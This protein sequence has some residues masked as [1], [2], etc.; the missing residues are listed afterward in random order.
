MSVF[1][2]EE[3]EELSVEELPGEDET[4][5]PSQPGA[6]TGYML[7]NNCRC[8]SYSYIKYDVYEY[9]NSVGATLP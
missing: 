3:E 5:H 1:V 4:D 8:P 2:D 9:C 6:H 7:G